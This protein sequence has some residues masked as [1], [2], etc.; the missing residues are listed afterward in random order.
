MP[1]TTGLATSFIQFSRP[2]ASGGGATVTDRDGKIKW[3]GHNLLLASESFDSS[4]WTKGANITISAN[5]A[6]SP[7]GTTTADKITSSAA[8]DA[9]TNRILQQSTSSVG[10]VSFNIWL[11]AATPQTVRLKLYDNNGASVLTTLDAAVTTTWTMF[12]VN[13]T[14]TANNAAVSIGPDGV[15]VLTSVE[16][17]GAH[18]Y[19]SDMGMQQNPAMPANMGSYYPTTPRN[20]LG[21]TEAFA[22]AY[23]TKT[24]TTAIAVSVTNPVGLSTASLV[25]PSSSGTDRCVYRTPALTGVTS[26]PYTLSVYAKANGINFLYFGTLGGGTSPA[27]LLAFFNLQA[28]TVTQTGSYFTSATI[29]PIGNGW[30]RCTATASPAS[31][32]LFPLFGLA[33]ANN[34]TTVT[35]S[36]TNGIYLWGAQLSDSAS[37]DPYVPVYGAAVSS[38][39]YYAPRLDFDGATLSPKGL[40]VEEARTN[41]ILHSNNFSQADWA[42]FAA[43]TGTT[44]VLTSGQADPFGGTTGWRLQANSGG[45]GAGNY[46]IMR[47]AIATTTSPRTVWVKS[48]TGSNQEIYFGTDAVGSKVTV[49]PAWQRVSVSPAS[50][51]VVF[52]IGSAPDISGNTTQSVDVLIWGAQVET[53]SGASVTFA[54]SYIPTGASTA[55]RTADVASV[56]T[57]AFPYSSSASSMVVSF[58][59]LGAGSSSYVLALQANGSSEGLNFLK[60][61]GGS[62][63]TTY[64]D[65]SSVSIGTAGIN[66]TAKAGI[67][68]DGVANGAVLNAGTVLSVGTTVSG[69]ATRLSLGSFFNQNFQMNGH[70]RQITYLPRRITNA[71]LQ[72][73]TL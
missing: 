31:G 52:D 27:S 58:D 66:T 73:R 3:A 26:T 7:N 71:E 33:D 21:F 28:G 14:V 65:T 59:L 5:S 18:L 12:T 44:P 72:S 48:N 46:S 36:G 67:A 16:A 30:Y 9:S 35:A 13:G 54:T 53:A 17:W 25:Y 24:S 22:D 45:T 49:T 19:R 42:K 56:S 68:Y 41:L 63:I 15:T 51:S 57:Q 34:S 69:A 40:L 23:W 32:S 8:S 6:V 20:L 61:G 47:Q 64:V 38:A 11:R 55:T 70:I 37:L 62:N 1:T 50:T 29:T 2:S 43:G 39:A 60:A 4:S 10:G